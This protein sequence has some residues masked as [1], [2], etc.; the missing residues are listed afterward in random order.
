MNVTL[1]NLFAL[2]LLLGLKHAFDADHI[3]AVST[4]I[5]KNKSTK[6]VSK[7]GFFWGFGHTAALLIIGFIILLFKISVPE[8]LAL[9]FEFIVGIMLVVLGLNVLI[10]LNKNKIH[11]HKHKHGKEEHIHF[12]S[13][14]TA[15]NH[16]HY[17]QPLAIGL[18]HGLAGSAALTLLALTT[19][20]SV[21]VGLVY[22]LIF[23]IG[24]MIGMILV[25]IIVSLP[26][27]LI[28]NRFERTHKILKLSTSIIS[29]VIGFS[30]IYTTSMILL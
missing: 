21:F 7:I 23:G 12:H 18:V 8:K 4:I 19:I 22:I 17:H 26:F 29:I 25:S 27:K 3:A 10:K 5:S 14:L 20:N 16:A 11:F 2:G 24:S 28:T 6:L 15:K 1:I 9:S 30:L 13:H